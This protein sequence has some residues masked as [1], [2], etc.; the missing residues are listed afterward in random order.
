MRA[1]AKEGAGAIFWAYTFIVLSL[2]L[3]IGAAAVALT[4]AAVG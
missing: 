3:V 1:G 2:G 4:W